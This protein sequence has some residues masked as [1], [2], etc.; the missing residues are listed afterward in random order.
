MLDPEHLARLIEAATPGPWT[1]DGPPSNQIIWR[2]GENRVCFMAHSNG[3]D[4]RRDEATAALIVYLVNHAPDILAL[5]HQPADR[6]TFSPY[7]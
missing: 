4:E 7:A 1:V 6:A 2:D 3:R 5:L